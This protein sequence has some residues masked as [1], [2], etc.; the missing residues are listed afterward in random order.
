V[1]R[2]PTGGAAM[3]RT[4]LLACCILTS[5]VLAQPADP[6]TDGDGMSDFRERHK[7]FTNPANADSD[8][9]GTPDGDRNERR[10]YA[11]SVRAV[12]HVTRPVNPDTL[13]D[14]YQDGR[15]LDEQPGHVEIEVILYPFNTVHEGMASARPGTWRSRRPEPWFK[16]FLDP[17][18]T[19]NWDAAM[20]RDLLAGLT[21]SGINLDALSDRDAAPKVAH[22]LLEH[23]Q[24]E[25]SFTTFAVQF[26]N[27]VPSVHPSARAGVDE[28]LKRRGRTLRE[29]WD[30][31]LLGAGMF[32][33]KTRGSCTSSAIYMTAGLRAAAIPTRSVVCV[34]VIDASDPWERQLPAHLAHHAV[35]RTIEKTAERLSNSWASHTFNEVYLGGVDG[36]WVRLNYDRLGQNIYDPELLGLMVHVHT[37]GDHAEAGLVNWGQRNRGAIKPDVCG[38]SNPYSCISLSDLFGA[39]ARIENPPPPP[40]GHTRLTIN[41]AYWY[42]QQGEPRRVQMRLDD[43]ETAGHLI[44][45]VDEAIEGEGTGQYRSFYERVGKDFVL[46]A[47]GRQ[48][49][50]A[51][52][53]RGYWVVPSSGVRDFYVQIPAAEFPRMAAGVAYELVA[54]DGPNAEKWVVQP[55]V[56]I[57]RPSP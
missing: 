54:I 55:G 38:G 10:E 17:G 46:R 13:T 22:W 32:L 19:A 57:V 29:Q 21:D 1:R 48:D 16:P 6:D 3:F 8:G 7:H 5:T 41:R 44:V 50:R 24:D 18:P 40:D 35:R 15:V 47:P 2:L 33:T 36:R 27:G 11:Y 37:F 28:E 34:P 31:E 52:A 12:M 14:D 51:V 43:P 26:E 42:H 9:D 20:Q 56:N 45:V 23:A 49:V 4:V 53:A 25:D 30:R 39:H